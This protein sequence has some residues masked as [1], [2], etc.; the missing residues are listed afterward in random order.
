MYAQIWPIPIAKASF[1]KHKIK[2]LLGSY[3]KSVGGGVYRH[4][5]KPL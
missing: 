3:F 5:H 2:K 4:S 1:V